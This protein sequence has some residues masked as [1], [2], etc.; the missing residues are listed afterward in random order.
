MRLFLFLL[1]ALACQAHDAMTKAAEAF[2]ATLDADRKAKAIFS[3]DDNHRFD[4]HYI[5]KKRDGLSLKAMTT[6]Q[7]LAAHALLRATLSERGYLQVQGVMLLEQVLRELESKGGKNADRRDWEN[8]FFSIFGTPDHDKPW[9]W[10]FEGHHLSL[11]FTSAGD[12]Q[13]IATT[14]AFFG[15]NPAEVRE[16]PLTGLKVLAGEEQLARDFMATLSDDQRKSALIKDKA[17]REILTQAKRDIAPGKPE[18]LAYAELEGQQRAALMELVHH[19]IDTF[20]KPLAARQ[21]A[22][23]D[24]AGRDAI[25][26]A[27]A[28]SL[29]PGEAHYYIVQGPTFLLEYVNFQN[30]ANHVHAVWRDPANDYGRDILRRH[31]ETH[32]KGDK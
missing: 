10:R 28:G 29:T 8:Y 21:R 11:S 6:E 25:H 20:K 5:P 3:L 16:G 15:S 9:A 17:P 26:F 12:E 30:G 23:I 24:D 32:H 13:L 14:P 7:R 2:L 31:M 27:W 22:R 1:L 4:W 19:Y 18:G